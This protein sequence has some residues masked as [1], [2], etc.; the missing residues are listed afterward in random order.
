MVL[1][2]GRE[3]L[4]RVV[5]DRRMLRRKRHINFIFFRNS[6][7]QVAQIQK[8]ERGWCIENINFLYKRSKEKSL[9]KTN[10]RKKTI[11]TRSL[12]W[13]SKRPTRENKRTYQKLIAIK[14]TQ[15]KKCNKNKRKCSRTCHPNRQPVDSYLVPTK[16]E[17]RKRRPSKKKTNPRA[18][19]EKG[20]RKNKREKQK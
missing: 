17:Q 19:E 13:I 12:V 5:L 10:E 11:G 8:E 9:S 20:I 1:H 2:V 18:F 4:A 15:P 3:G 7:R 6:H 16:E 14:K